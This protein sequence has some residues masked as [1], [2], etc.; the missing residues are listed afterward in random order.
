V[1]NRIQVR[2]YSTDEANKAKVLTVKDLYIS[3]LVNELNSSTVDQAHGQ[4][5]EKIKALI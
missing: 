1:Y 2:L 5:L 3:Y 4:T